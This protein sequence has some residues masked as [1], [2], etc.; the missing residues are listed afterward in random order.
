MAHTAQAP[1]AAPPR[2]IYILMLLGINAFNHDA[3][4]C[5]VDPNQRRVLFAGHAER[6]SRVKNDKLIN[7]EL[8]LDLLQYGRPTELC[9]FEKPMLRNLRQLRSGQWPQFYSIENF[10][11]RH[12]LGN[13]PIHRYHHHRAHAAQAFY[14]KNMHSAG[15]LVIDAIG[16]WDTTSIW[17][18]QGS[19]LQCKWRRWYPDSMGLFYSAVTAGLGF[20]PN[21]EEYIVM[22]MAAHG[23][24]CYVE[25]LKGLFFSEFSPPYFTLRHN[26]HRGIH[27][28]LPQGLLPQNVAASA[29]WIW[30]EYLVET[31]KWM[32]HRLGVKNL[33]IAGGGALN[34]TANDRIRQL[35]LF[36]EVY[37]PANPG[38]AGLA[39]GA[40][41]AHLCR[42]LEIPTAYLGHD[43]RRRVPINVVVS[44]LEAGEIVGIANGRAEWGPR[45]L[46]NRSLLADPRSAGM[47]S[48]V[49]DI[50]G[51]EHFRPFSPAVLDEH[52]DDIF[53]VDHNNM[54]NMQFAVRCHDP[55]S[56][57]AVCHVDNTARIQMVDRYNPSVLRLILEEWHRRTGCPMLLNT[58][59][60][61]RGEPLVNTVADAQRFSQRKQLVVF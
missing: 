23:K 32:H 34:C 22:G 58:S 45:A 29:Q 47:Q 38:D 54:Q 42:P 31:A 25:L 24:P 39:L 10:L 16:E 14:T 4:A 40:T 7:D 26:L 49:N 12:K 55:E 21:E 3:S 18:A 46:G 30:E 51:R 2:S 61:G 6:Y 17:L 5:L 43:I 33:V 36:D 9:W 28:W 53:D 1:A 15:V 37:V 60:N 8:L 44:M 19:K 13:L 35:G 50:K 52:A 57:P 41:A 11:R 20:K 56:Y 59:L 27:R 48:R